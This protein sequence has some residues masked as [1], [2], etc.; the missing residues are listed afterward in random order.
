MSNKENR[1]IGFGNVRVICASALLCALS[2]VIA[3]LCKTYLTFTFLGG[4]VRFTLENLPIVLSG[5]WFGP[6]SGAAVGLATDFISTALS[7]YG[8]GAMNPYITVGSAAVGLVAGLVARY[9]R[10]RHPMLRIALCD[11]LAHTVGSGI[12]KTTGLYVYHFYVTIPL[13]GREISSLW[14]RIP[15]YLV[16]AAVEIYLIRVIT[17]N[18]AIFAQINRICGTCQ[19]EQEK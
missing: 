6:I 9:G 7:Q 13:F 2:V 18:K 8:I 1:R 14:L 17:R 11:G 4:S 16:I 5:Y 12:L 10:F 15:T 3:W 19:G